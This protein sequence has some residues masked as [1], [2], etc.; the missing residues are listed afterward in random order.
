MSEVLSDISG[1]F[2]YFDDIF[3]MSQTEQEYRIFLHQ[4]LRDQ[5][6]TVNPNKCILG[7][8]SSQ[9][10]GH[11]VS[12][13]G[14]QPYQSNVT[15]IVEYERPRT[16]KQLL[17]FLGMLQFYSRFVELLAELLNP[18]YAFTKTGHARFTW[19]M[20]AEDS[21]VEVK[22]F[23]S[24]HCYVIAHK[25]LSRINSRFRQCQNKC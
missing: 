16:R 24:S 6:C 4:S 12:E 7:V 3:L 25:L 5:N 10:L 9:F 18:P 21:F 2:F 15:A 1:V 22:I 11:Y 19:T 20:E 17:T 13:K 14:L 23:S 8:S